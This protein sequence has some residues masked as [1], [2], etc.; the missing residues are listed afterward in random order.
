MTGPERWEL[1]EKI[2]EELKKHPEGLWVRKLA[3]LL[4]EPVMTVHKYVTKEGY[5]KRY[6]KVKKLP[7]EEGGHLMIKIKGVKKDMEDEEEEN[8]ENYYIS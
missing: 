6:L 8:T 2:L 5:L 1:S 3:R 4:D 7:K